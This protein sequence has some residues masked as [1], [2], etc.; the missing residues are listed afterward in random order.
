M[1]RALTRLWDRSEDV[2]LR[3]SESGRAALRKQAASERMLKQELGMQRSPAIA[4]ADR[5]YRERFAS[6][7]MVGVRAS[8]AEIAER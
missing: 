6:S 3:K 7:P 2:E 8:A 1:E 5:Y 4:D